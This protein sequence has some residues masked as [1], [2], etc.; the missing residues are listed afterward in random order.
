MPTSAGN[1]SIYKVSLGDLQSISKIS[2]GEKVV[3]SAGNAVTYRVDTNNVYTE[4][5][6]EGESCLSL[7]SFTPAKSGWEF[8]GWRQDTSAGGNV[9]G[10]LVMGDVPIT[11][12]AVFRQSVTVTYYNNSATAGS[13]S[14]YR[15]YN[16]GNTVN[17]S[18]TL[19]Q[20]ARSG[21][22]ASGWS[23]GNTGNSG[24]TYNNGAAFTRDSSITLYGMYQQ[25][26]TVTYYNN[27]TTASTTSGTRYYN[28][29]GAVVNPSFTLSQAARSGWTARGW[30]TSTAGNGGITYNNSVAFTRDSNVT[31]YGMY[32]QTVT[33]TY[34]NG[35]TTAAS[36]FG[37][38]YYNPGSGGV[39]NPTFSL[40][41]ATLSGWTF[42]G[43]A[44]SSDAAAGIAY[45]SISN[46]AFSSSATVYAAYSQTITL[47]Y[48]GNGSTGGSTASQTG[49]RYF[50]TGNYS[51]PSFNLSANG[52][53]KTDH[54]FQKW[55][56][57]SAS[58]TQYATGASVTLTAS[59]TFYAVWE[60]KNTAKPAP[61]FLSAGWRTLY[62]ERY[63][64]YDKLHDAYIL[65]ADFEDR[66]IAHILENEIDT[67]IFWIR[68]D[69]G[70]DKAYL[71]CSP[72]ISTGSYAHFYMSDAC[73]NDDDTSEGRAWI[74]K[75]DV[76]RFSDDKTTWTPW[77]QT[78]NSIRSYKYAQVGA[79]YSAESDSAV[80]MW[81]RIRV[82]RVTF[83]S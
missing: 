28:S 59:I 73:E 56:I 11:L 27:S 53:S 35:S 50:N 51:N 55:A 80:D 66:G 47:S 67:Q 42:R 61:P 3:Y 33:L 54:E 58:G 9:L 48:N 6:D 52:F 65:H 34:Y 10:G 37:T 29:N 30:S 13:T 45:S 1:I 64:F 24:I 8:V 60:E 39:I 82:T 40:V 22:T 81:Y 14:A 62:T 25:T 32:Q 7:K 76:S 46:T 43:W 83:Y 44:A 77:L 71:F 19:T 16:N 49:T 36:T 20:A 15:Y 78:S 63:S 57:G 74:N 12:Y 18:F 41:P 2:L 38:R 68:G 75:F 31:L 72:I 4:E 69:E 26:V 17:P 23:T 5:V 21:W 79:M 70:F